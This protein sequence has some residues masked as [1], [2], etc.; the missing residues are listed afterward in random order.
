MLVCFAFFLFDVLVRAFLVRAFLV[1]VFLVEVVLVGVVKNDAVEFEQPFGGVRRQL[2]IDLGRAGE[3]LPRLLAAVGGQQRIRVRVPQP[4]HP[5][6]LGCRR[7]LTYLQHRDGRVGL[8]EVAA[9]TGSHDQQLDDLLGGELGT[10]GRPVQVDRPLRPAERPLAVRDDRDV[11][12]LSTQSV[13]RA[14][15]ADRHLPLLR[16]VRGQADGFPYRSDPR[17]PSP[18][19]QRVL[20]RQLGIDVDELAG[21]DEPAGHRFRG[22]P[23][24]QAQ[25]FA[26]LGS[27]LTRVD[28]VGERRL[29]GTG[30]R[31]DVVV[32]VLAHGLARPLE[33]APA[34]VVA[35]TAVPITAVA[36]SAVPITVVA[37]ST[38]PVSVSVSVEAGARAVVVAPFATVGNPARPVAVE[39][40]P[41]S[42]IAVAIMTAVAV[43]ALTWPVPVEAATR[44]VSLTGEPAARPIEVT[45]FATAR[46]TVEAS[47]ALVRTA[48]AT[49]RSTIR[50][51][52][53]SS[54]EATRPIAVRV[55]T[56]VEATRTIA[57]RVEATRT[58]T[59]VPAARPIEVTSAATVVAARAATITVEPSLATLRPAVATVRSAVA[60][61]RTTIEAALVTTIPAKVPARPVTIEPTPVSTIST[62]SAISTVCAC[63]AEAATTSVTSLRVAPAEVAPFS[64]GPVWGAAFVAAAVPARAIPTRAT[65]T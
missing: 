24:E 51:S 32:A 12:L 30:R 22:V 6:R 59:V 46:V 41:F 3:P 44:P 10:V 18:R 7:E 39:L 4:R 63:S 17:R 42:A 1:L 57:V 9:R 28:I 37:W 11:G 61:V 36:W 62:V 33:V 5:R 35:I 54:V 55:R 2:L 14:Q 8:T 49:V 65:A 16:V 20:K 31:L 23:G 29:C 58:V 64:A 25:F 60:T 13:V 38:V 40:R 21:G 56:S 27:Q 19:R 52:V 50:P 45:P 53:R 34:T 26:Y 43:E 48:V 47:P 15:L